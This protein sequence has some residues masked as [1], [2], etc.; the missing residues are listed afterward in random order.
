MVNES[1]IKE[2]VEAVISEHSVIAWKEVLIK[3]L[4]SPIILVVVLVFILLIFKKQ[5]AEILKGRDIDIGWGNSHIKLN[6][7]S[8]SI[9]KELD[10]LREE[11]ESLKGTINELRAEES[12][13]I[14]TIASEEEREKDTKHIK[15]CIYKA[16]ASPKFRWRSI[17][18]LAH[19]ANATEEQ[20]LELISADQSIEIG[21]DKSGRRLIKF[22]HR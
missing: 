9:D 7:L 5:L 13:I 6:E 16:L 20:V 21:H 19:Y 8:K 18:K 4:E 14:K 10:P 3:A 2:I 1:Q 15:G 22:K 11:I 12:N 17:E